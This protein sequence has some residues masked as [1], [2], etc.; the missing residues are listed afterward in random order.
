MPGIRTKSITLD[1]KQSD[2]TGLLTESRTEVTLRQPWG[3]RRVR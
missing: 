3:W 2:S 1:T